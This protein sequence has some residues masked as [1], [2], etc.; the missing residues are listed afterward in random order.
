[1]D[2]GAPTS[3]KSLFGSRP[4]LA[5]AARE[6]ARRGTAYA[7]KRFS[8]YGYL[9]F[10]LGASI[11]ERRSGLQQITLPTGQSGRVRSVAAIGSGVSPSARLS[12]SPQPSSSR[13]ITEAALLGVV[14]QVRVDVHRGVVRFTNCPLT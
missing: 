7:C 8:A 5:L 3:S 6:R 1:M 10:E 4:Q 11:F 13:S 9:P 2:A 12:T 14:E